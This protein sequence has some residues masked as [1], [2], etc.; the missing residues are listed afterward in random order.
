MTARPRVIRTADWAAPVAPHPR[1]VLRRD[2]DAPHPAAPPLLFLPDR[3]QP[4]DEYAAR[5]LP[6]AARRGH[7]AAVLAP[8]AA[9]PPRTAAALRVAVHDAVQA[10]VALPRRAVLCGCGTGALV[11]RYAMA[12][13]AA[14]AVVLLNPPR[15]G[16]WRRR[17][18]GAPEAPAGRPRVVVAGCPDD[19]DTSAAVLAGEAARHG[20]GPLLFPGRSGDL[21]GG[22]AG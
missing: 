15:P 19:P 20:G 2:P 5:W 9:D 11:A 7:C 16:W 22:D 4:A 14:A 3:R 18:L 8:R 13:Y 6:H 21:L 1:R 17:R 10:A 12:R